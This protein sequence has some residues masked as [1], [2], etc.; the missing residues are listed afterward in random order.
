[1]KTLASFFTKKFIIYAV[2][3]V[4]VAGIGGYF[5]FGNKNNG[6][7]TLTVH[8]ADFLQQVS[9]SATIAANQNLDLSF[10]DAGQVSAVKVNVGDNVSAGQLLAGQNTAQLDA[11]LSSMQAGIDLEKAKLNQLL[12][13]SSPEE[14]KTAQDAVTLANQ[15]IS[16]A[17]A[18]MLA[19]L[20]SAYVA[21]YNAY[22][23]ADHIQYIY[24]TSADP[25]G[26]QVQQSKSSIY[27]SLTDAKNNVDKRKT[28]IIM[29]ILMRP[30]KAPPAA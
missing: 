23:T 26:I 20:A 3:A 7:Q 22:T 13:G 4:A 17:Y 14:I 24:F 11:Q 15:N 29:M 6:P 5:L 12:A 8:P 10:E 19:T 25:E 2:V 18:S 30:L 21:I 1:M 27:A 9:S 28:A 16:N